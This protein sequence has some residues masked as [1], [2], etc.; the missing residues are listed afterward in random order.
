MT[1]DYRSVETRDAQMT[2]D[3]G[4]LPDFE[5]PPVTETV[6]GVEF[7]PLSG[8]LIPHFGL[9]WERIRE[10]YP[11]VQVVPPL[12]PSTEEGEEGVFV[13]VEAP[14]VRCW[15]LEPAKN[16]LIQ[17]QHD[18][19]IHNW[20][21]FAEGEVEY[22]RYEA[23]IRPRFSR[24][25]QRF[26]AF[27]GEFG[28]ES[29]QVARCEVSYINQLERGREWQEH[30]DIAEAIRTLNRDSSF[31]SAPVTTRAQWTYK[32]PEGKGR[33][34][35]SLLPAIRHRDAKEIYQLSLIAKGPPASSESEDILGWFDLGRE[36]IVRGFADLTTSKM[37][38]LWKRIS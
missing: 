25:W 17:V 31:L 4:P 7:Q 9:F 36:W 37:H 5:N 19:F 23:A 35:V 15:F 30:Q 18:R 6:L 38:K 21:K 28:I 11:H 33:L 26:L 34:Q 29:P 24:E 27:L 12:G 10:E 2:R 16:R 1:T 22:P 32:M 14:P 20:R 8:W 13:S 3:W